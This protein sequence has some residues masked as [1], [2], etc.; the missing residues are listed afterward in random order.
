MLCLLL[1]VLL[2][3]SC[4]SVWL[5]SQAVCQPAAGAHGVWPRVYWMAEVKHGDVQVLA[6]IAEHLAGSSKG[7]QRTSSVWEACMKRA[8]CA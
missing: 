7:M 6:R 1:A 8:G 5:C 2:V 3:S 4:S